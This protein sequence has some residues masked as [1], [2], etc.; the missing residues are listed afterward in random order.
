MKLPGTTPIRA[1]LFGCYSSNSP[2]NR[3]PERSASQIY[4]VTQRLWVRSRRTSRML[5]LAMLLVPFRA[6]KPE[7]GIAQRRAYGAQQDAAVF[8]LGPWGKTVAQPLEAGGLRRLKSSEQQ[9]QDEHP[10]GP[11]TAPPSAVSRDKFV[12]RFAQDDGFVAS[13]RSKQSA[14]SWISIVCQTS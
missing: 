8:V 10:R 12:R 4:R 11:S 9:G 13:W 7:N 1:A 3:H 2:Q 6:P 14:F 5:I